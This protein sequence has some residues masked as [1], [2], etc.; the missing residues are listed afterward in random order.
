MVA[1]T[2]PIFSVDS[3]LSGLMLPA[4]SVRTW[5]SSTIHASTG[6]PAWARLPSHQFLGGWV[7]VFEALPE[8]DDGEAASSRFWLIWTASHQSNAISR[9]SKR[10]PNC[11]TKVSMPA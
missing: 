11:S 1:T 2:P 3:C 9:M 6:W 7:H 5:M 4:G 10:S 8:G